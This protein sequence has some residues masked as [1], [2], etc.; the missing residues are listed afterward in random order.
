M[1]KIANLLFEARKLKDIP[2]SGYQFLEAGGETVA[3]HSFM[4]TFIAFVLSRMHPDI[5]HDKLIRMCLVHDLPETRT[6]DL[7][8]VQKRYVAPD[9]HRA[10]EDALSGIPFKADIMN[11]IEEF[12][13]GTTPE[14][15]LARDADQLAFILD[16]KALADLGYKPPLK[17]LNNV[18]GRLFT[19]TGKNLAESILATDSDAWWMPDGHPVD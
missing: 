2:R 3:E 19:D 18:V 5:D 10:M 9:E 7:N 13:E 17:W 14:A 16:L 1:R 6:G 15:R 8:H 11:L 4:A 12:N